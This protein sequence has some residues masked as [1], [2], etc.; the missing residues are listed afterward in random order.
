MDEDNESSLPDFDWSPVDDLFVTFSPDEWW[1]RQWRGHAEL[2][3]K[4]RVMLEEAVNSLE[5]LTSERA[6][7]IQNFLKGWPEGWSWGTD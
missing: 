5:G 3:Q 2:G 4:L 1:E 7:Q 6:E